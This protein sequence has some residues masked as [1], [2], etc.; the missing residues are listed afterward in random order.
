MRSLFR[1]FQRSI[2]NGLLI[3]ALFSGGLGWSQTLTDN[4]A[5]YPPESDAGPSWEPRA[6][7][8]TV[9]D[10]GYQGEEEGSVWRAAPWAA[11]ARFACDVTVREQLTGDWLTAGIGFQLDE[12]N[13]WALNL[14]AAPEG[15]Q[16]KHSA[17]MQEMLQ[18]GWLAQVQTS[19][20]LE[21]LP[22][23]G[24]AFNWKL[25]QT[26]RLELDLTASNIIGRVLEGTEEVSRFGY[27]LDS[28]AP[29]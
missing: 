29:A 8:W 18:G 26:Y 4:F 21:Q 15:Q 10:G 1:G 6:A 11:S 16:R 12:R 7:G 17:E 22:S 13:Y 27:R 14:V 24:T 9:I 28:T 2:L 19:T 5:S 23:H 25:G 20:R 3:I